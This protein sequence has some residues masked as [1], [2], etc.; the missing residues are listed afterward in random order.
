[1]ANNNDGGKNNLSI[2]EL[3]EGREE[4]N[5]ATTRELIEYTSKRNIWTRTIGLQTG[6]GHSCGR[7]RHKL[8]KGHNRLN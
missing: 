1:M 6:S 4:E 7:E 5:G 3:F 8:S 2:H